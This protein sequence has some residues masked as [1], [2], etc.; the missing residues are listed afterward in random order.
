MP[1]YGYMG[2]IMLA[3]LAALENNVMLKTQHSCELSN[4]DLVLESMAQNFGGFHEAHCGRCL[5]T[6]VKESYLGSR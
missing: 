6:S 4:V 1:L 2:Q 5:Q 3:L